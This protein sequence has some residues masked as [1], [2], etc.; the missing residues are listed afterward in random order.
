MGSGNNSGCGIEWAS[1]GGH[2][3]GK[4]WGKW[5]ENPAEWWVV[6]S[7]KWKVARQVGREFVGSWVEM[8]SGNDS[9]CEI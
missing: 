5:L 3:C 9:E 2:M 1:G 7:E 6:V 8:G 4:L